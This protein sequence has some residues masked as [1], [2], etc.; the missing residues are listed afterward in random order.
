MTTAR[1][2][3]Q[4]HPGKVLPVDPN[5]AG[6]DGRV[7]LKYGTSLAKRLIRMQL[8]KP[9]MACQHITGL[10]R[11]RFWGWGSCICFPSWCGVYPQSAAGRH[12][13]APVDLSQLQARSQNVYNLLV[14]LVL[15]LLG[16]LCLSLMP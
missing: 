6:P 13:L 14:W 2:L 15:P 3:T 12:E 9:G 10:E 5:V 1:P 11:V 8:I 4:C 16:L 7:T